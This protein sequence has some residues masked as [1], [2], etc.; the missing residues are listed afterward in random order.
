MKYL[1]K[2]LGRWN[3]GRYKEYECTQLEESSTG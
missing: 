3:F 2:T 1:K